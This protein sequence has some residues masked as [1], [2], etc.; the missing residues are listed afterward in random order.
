MPEI[1]DRKLY[2]LPRSPRRMRLSRKHGGRIRNYTYMVELLPKTRS[3]PE[4]DAEKLVDEGIAEQPK[5]RLRT[6]ASSPFTTTDPGI[7]Q[8]FFGTL[9]FRE[10]TASS[11]RGNSI[12]VRHRSNT[13]ITVQ[14]RHCSARNVQEIKSEPSI[15]V[16][17]KT[18][19]KGPLLAPQYRSRAATGSSIWI[20]GVKSPATATEP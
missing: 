10:R 9:I 4:T 1:D 15:V 19:G 3:Q 6:A 14:R 8:S 17:P 7:S 16:R 18:A 20:S 13:E 2:S 12:V 11:A 5:E